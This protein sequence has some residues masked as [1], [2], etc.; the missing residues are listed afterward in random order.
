VEGSEVGVGIR[1]Y[2]S[3]SLP[4]LL[5]TN[6]RFSINVVVL[7]SRKRIAS[8]SCDDQMVLEHPGVCKRQQTIDDEKSGTYFPRHGSLHAHLE[9][10]FHTTGSRYKKPGG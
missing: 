1:W 10:T 9:C 3:P 5:T 7:Y 6:H 2:A 4:N 8:I